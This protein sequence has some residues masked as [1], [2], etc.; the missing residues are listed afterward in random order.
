MNLQKT[1]LDP[2]RKP[3]GLGIEHTVAQL[4]H[5]HASLRV[6]PDQTTNDEEDQYIYI[7]YKHIL[8]K[9]QIN[10]S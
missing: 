3:G 5:E 7:S 4:E 10:K 2:S 8:Y 6:P 1:G 9:N